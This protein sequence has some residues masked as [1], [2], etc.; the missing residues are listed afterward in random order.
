V[1][2]TDWICSSNIQSGFRVAQILLHDMIIVRHLSGINECNHVTTD[3]R[4]E[5]PGGACCTCADF[6]FV[7]KEMPFFW[8][9]LRQILRL[10]SVKPS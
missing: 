6:D 8:K 1:N 2:C 5:S 7:N 10:I 3:I 4:D 9:Y